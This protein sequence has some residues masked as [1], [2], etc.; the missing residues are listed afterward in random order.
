MQIEQAVQFLT[1]FN[2]NLDNAFSTLAVS[3]PDLCDQVDRLIEAL[4]SINS[5]NGQNLL[6]TYYQQ[7]DL[8][9]LKMKSYLEENIQSLQTIIQNV[10]E[11][12]S[13]IDKLTRHLSGIEDLASETKLISLNAAI[14][15]ERLGSKG[16]AFGVIT[17]YLTKVS[18]QGDETALT[19]L[20]KTESILARFKSLKQL[21]VDLKQTLNQLVQTAQEE[22]DPVTQ[23]VRNQLSE[24]SREHGR[25]LEQC[26]E[27]LPAV[28]E[29][30]LLI[31]N[32]DV[33]RQGIEHISIVLHE[34]E[35]V[36]SSHQN[37]TPDLRDEI[38]FHEHLE[39]LSFQEKAGELS[40]NLYRDNSQELQDF[41]SEVDAKLNRVAQVAFAIV[42]M[43]ERFSGQDDFSARLV[44]P[45][46][47]FRSVLDQSNEIL[48][49][50]REF[51]SVCQNLKETLNTLTDDLDGFTGFFKSM[52]RIRLLMKIE[53]GSVPELSRD[54]QP[55]TQSIQKIENELKA[56]LKST[57]KIC[58]SLDRQR[59]RCTNV[60][61]YVIK[62]L[63]NLSANLNAEFD[64]LSRQFGRST[65][66]FYQNSSQ[67]IDTGRA[68]DHSVKEFQSFLP[69][70]QAAFME[71][72]IVQTTCQS[73]SDSA[74]QKQAEAREQTGRL[75]AEESLNDHFLDLIARF[76]TL[77]H[78][79]ILGAISGID[80]EEG[81]C[82]GELTLF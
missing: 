68:I 55:I 25:I 67:A 23:S 17:Q 49:S 71:D 80:I 60:L 61:D 29:V 41:F 14:A 1:D 16:R 15:S 45:L 50:Y 53:A 5:Q 27:I 74:R 40:A 57:E 4:D 48:V 56:L 28:Q 12:E 11:T 43:E 2:Q 39:E 9:S 37:T 24:L 81:D 34:I 75:Y 13:N 18:Q 30:M 73:I 35:N 64:S 79:E 32:Q 46:D 70:L 3:L 51:E 31:Q 19:F 47:R 65:E 10:D 66:S 69:Q 76:T 36:H 63:P 7:I 33:L 59:D 22:I 58:R 62:H 78:K 6:E 20:E 44:A 21:S 8:L 26:R 82:G 72:N 52:N 54:A 38:Q 77:T 42:A